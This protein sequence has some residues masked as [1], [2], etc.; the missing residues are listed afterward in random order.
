MNF[1]HSIELNVLKKI[2][3]TKEERQKLFEIANYL[4]KKIHNAAYKYEIDSI[5][6]KVVGSAARD[7]FISGNHDLDLFITFPKETTRENLETHGLLIAKEVSKEGYDI[8]ERYAEH[9]YLHMKYKE[10]NIDLVPCFRVESPA[11][12]QSAVDRTP[13]HNQFVKEHIKKK[14]CEVLLLKQFMDACGVRGSELRKAA[15]SGYLIELLI[16]YYGS[17]SLCIHAADTWKPN[18]LIDLKN[19][20]TQKFKT[21]LI[22]IDPTDPARNVA[23]ALSIDKFCTFIDYSREFIKNPSEKFFFPDEKKPITNSEIIEKQKNKGSSIIAIVFEKPDIIDD[24]FYPQLYKMEQ[25]IVKLI[26]NHEFKIFKSGTWAEDGIA[27]IIIDLFSSTLPNIKHNIGPPIWEKVHAERFKSKYQVRDCYSLYIKNGKFIAEIPRE[28]TD[29]RQLIKS[30]IF[31]C[32]I[33]S[34]IL[35]SIKKNFKILKDDGI[36]EIKHPLFRTYLKEWL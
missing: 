8:E 29:I 9:P 14:Q 12:I 32:S 21:P 11:N 28:F 31:E 30:K 10:Y 24:I 6:A 4:I 17:F 18:L 16:I 1:I 22:V 5:Q 23:A 13:F 35:P 15:F 2:R 27:V 3:P 34:Y 20:G 19:H 36:C 7:T 25:S 33:G 26:E